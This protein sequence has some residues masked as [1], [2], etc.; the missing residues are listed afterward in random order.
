VS[1]DGGRT[2]EFSGFRHRRTDEKKLFTEGARATVSKQEDYFRR[3]G[4]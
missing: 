3:G 4:N 2:Q 1:V